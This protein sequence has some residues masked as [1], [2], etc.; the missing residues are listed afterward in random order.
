LKSV[1]RNIEELS[2]DEQALYKYVMDVAKQDD[3]N[4]Y[5]NVFLK[6]LDDPRDSIREVGIFA[7]LFQVHSKSHK[8]KQEAIKNAL[9]KNVDFDL[10]NWSIS[11]LGVAYHN[12]RDMKLMNLMMTILNDEAEKKPFRRTALSSLLNIY[13]LTTREITLRSGLYP[14]QADFKEELQTIEHMLKIDRP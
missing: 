9:D 8:A 7:L 2:H 1:N 5:E 6:L 10:R 3:V 13:G 4:L 14:N 11:G 12:S